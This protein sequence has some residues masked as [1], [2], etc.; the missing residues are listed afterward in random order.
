MVDLG[1]DASGLAFAA[2]R[3]ATWRRKNGVLAKRLPCLRF[4]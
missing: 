2:E 4:I 1:V 3:P